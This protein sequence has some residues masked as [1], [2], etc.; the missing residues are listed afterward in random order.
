VI[1]GLLDQVLRGW[2]GQA[3]PPSLDWIQVEVTSRCNALCSYC[4][5]TIYQ[6]AWADRDLP[7]ETFRKL[8]PAFRKT[9]MVHLQG[10]GEPFLHPAFFEL[11]SL[12]KKAGCTVG[13]TT[14]GMLL[15]QPMLERIADSG[16]DVLAFS[17]AGTGEDNDRI[18]KG[19]RFAA[20]IEAIRRAQDLKRQRG[21]AAPSVHIA[22][23]L[24]KS[25]LD[26]CDRLPP[27]LEGI[28]IRQVVISTLDFVG[29]EGVAAEALRPESDA[30]HAALSSKLQ[31]IVTA[32]ARHGMEGH[33][34]LASPGRRRTV[35]T[36]NIK[37]ALFVS[38][39]GSV[40][41][42]VYLNMPAE[43]VGG[44]HE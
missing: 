5:R 16:L 33:F 38:A 30:E 44:S 32:L 10:W 2:A 31:D 15:H 24:L 43:G 8:L 37:R 34:R 39:D 21:I 12:A 3:Q 4:P 23:M 36:E 1:K 20:V 29:T 40:S 11:V 27:L 17:L 42:C 26:T 19:T 25:G 13:T 35:C 18:R 6:S 7:L 41:P 22:Y 28:G 9:T 14:N